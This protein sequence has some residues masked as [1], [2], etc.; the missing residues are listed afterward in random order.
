[1]EKE[2]NKENGGQLHYDIGNANESILYNQESYM[3]VV[4]APS[5]YNKNKRICFITTR[6][7]CHLPLYQNLN[8]DLCLCFVWLDASRTTK[9]YALMNIK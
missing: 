5:Y 2:K 9:Y 8:L 7:Y 3:F 4:D 6:V 1:M